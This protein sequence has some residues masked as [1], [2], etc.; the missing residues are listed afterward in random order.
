M[1][2]YGS[3]E[4]DASLLMI[5]LVGF[6][7]ADDPRVRG[8]VDGDRARADARRASCTRYDAAEAGVDGLPPGEG[9]FLP[10]TFWL[11]DNLRLMGRRDEARALFERLLGLRNDV[12]LLAEEYDPRRGRLVGNFPQ[13]F[14]HVGAGQHRAQ[15][16]PR[17][18]RP[19][20]R[21]P[22]RTPRSETLMR[23]HHRSTRASRTRPTWRSVPSPGRRRR[24]NPRRRRR[25]RDLRDRRGDR[26]RRLRRAR[27]PAPSGSSSATSRSGGCSRRRPAAASPPGDLVVG[28]VR[29]PDPVPCPQLRGR[30][31]GHVPQRPLHRARHQGAARVRPRALAGRAA[32]SRSSSTR[33]SGCSACCSSRP[34]SWPRPGST[35]TG[36]AARAWSTPQ[37]VL[38]TGAGP[39]GLLAALLG[40]PARPRG[41]RARPR[42]P[43][44]PSRSS[45]RDLGATYHTGTSPSSS[46][47]AGRDPRV[48]RA[49]PGRGRRDGRTRRADGIVCL[50]G[51]PPAAAPIA[52]DAGALNRDARARERR[53]LRLGQRQPPPLRAARPRRWPPPT[54]RWL[55]RADH[56]PGPARAWHEALDATPTTSRSWSSSAPPLDPGRRPWDD[57]R[58]VTTCASCG[59]RTRTTMTSA[60]SAARTCAGTR[61]RRKPTRRS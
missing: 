40:A 50:T 33:R 39:I 52:L 29:R 25:G 22:S 6:L 10:C 57:R 41:A 32:N 36:S 19:A 35:S 26:P 38:V 49:P 54:A 30:R 48:H 31:V 17:A 13:A 34:A 45:S 27:R 56:P 12:G 16:R 53:R 43:T 2:S 1:Q 15:P 21:G 4:L 47:D 14:T 24:S 23:A 8:T 11:A 9:A 7:P 51:S 5:P 46:L 37:R 59:S 61:I 44:G 18:H 60:P 58:D 20:R 28:I 55:E 3:K 42:R